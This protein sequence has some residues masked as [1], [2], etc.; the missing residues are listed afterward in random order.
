MTSQYSTISLFIISIYH[1]TLS[2][3]ETPCLFCP[4]KSEVIPNSKFY[5]CHGRNYIWQVIMNNSHF[6]KWLSVDTIHFSQTCPIVSP[7][8]ETCLEEEDFPHMAIGCT[9]RTASV[10]LKHAYRTPYDFFTFLVLV[11]ILYLEQR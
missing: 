9:P 1:F 7:K 3:N 10:F 5:S 2:N 11:I 4:I 8:H 6:L